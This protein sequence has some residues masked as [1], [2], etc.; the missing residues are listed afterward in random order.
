MQCDDEREGL[1]K[2]KAVVLCVE[3]RKEKEKGRK[4]LQ[5]K[6]TTHPPSRWRAGINPRVSAQGKRVPQPG[7]GDGMRREKEGRKGM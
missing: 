5:K 2:S 1:P 6:A 7:E 3:T 4:A